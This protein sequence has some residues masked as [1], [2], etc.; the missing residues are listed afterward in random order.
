MEI[1][2]YNKAKV[3]K[4]LSCVCIIHTHTIYLLIQYAQKCDHAFSIVT[5]CIGEQVAFGPDSAVVEDGGEI[6]R[7]R[8]RHPVGLVSDHQIKPRQHRRC[9]WGSRSNLTNDRKVVRMGQSRSH[10]IRPH[11]ATT[12]PPGSQCPQSGTMALANGASTDRTRHPD[13]HSTRRSR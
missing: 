10:H 11:R 13:S 3:R 8:S 6:R 7:N 5:I 9:P 2:L 4:G 12:R 1:L